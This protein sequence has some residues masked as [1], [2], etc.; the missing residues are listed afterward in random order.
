MSSLAHLASSILVLTFPCLPFWGFAG[1]ACSR[2]KVT[3]WLSLIVEFDCWYN[4]QHDAGHEKCQVLLTVGYK[5]FKSFFLTT[6]HLNLAWVR[7]DDMVLS[8]WKGCK[9]TNFGP[10]P[11]PPSIMQIS[12]TK[13][14][15]K[16]QDV[17][18]CLV[19]KRARHIGQVTLKPFL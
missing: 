2:V 16:F 10:P 7:T 14:I 18:R 3:Y 5:N 8:H 1:Q 19:V 12:A 11:F 13:A 4:G 15:Y 17:F 9:P 6:L